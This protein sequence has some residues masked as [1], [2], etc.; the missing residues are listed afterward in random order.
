MG[1]SLN[2]ASFALVVRPEISK[3]AD[4]KG[5]R[6]GVGR[7]GDTPYFYTL[8]LLAKHGLGAADVQWV[9]V[10]SDTMGRANVLLGGQI[11]AALL[12]PPAYFVLERQGLKTIDNVSNHS[13]ILISTAYVFKKS[14]F[15]GHVAFSSL[16]E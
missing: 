16:D 12:T 13:D 14:W 9:A 7:V 1:S 6:I 3:I 5:K 15:F 8:D 10:P 11:D 4:L 2:K